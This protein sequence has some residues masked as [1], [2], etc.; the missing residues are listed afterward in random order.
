[1][2]GSPTFP[3]GGETKGFSYEGFPLV[4]FFPKVTAI[5]HK[6]EVMRVINVR[7]EIRSI[8]LV[9]SIN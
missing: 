5:W 7:D 3:S 6:G 2:M 8:I 1:M 9:D 4:V